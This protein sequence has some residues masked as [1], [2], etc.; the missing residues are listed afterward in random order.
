VHSLSQGVDLALGKLFRATDFF[1]SQQDVVDPTFLCSND[2]NTDK[3]DF[4]V[5]RQWTRLHKLVQM[6]QRAGL[7]PGKVSTPT[8]Y[9]SSTGRYVADLDPHRFW[10]AGSGSASRRAKMSHE[11]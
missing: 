8:R 4:Y 1:V 6:A 5:Q 10:S 11:P 3:C 2:L 7:M 9:Q